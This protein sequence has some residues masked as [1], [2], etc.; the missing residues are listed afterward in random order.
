MS[1]KNKLEQQS[2]E[3]Q[4]LSQQRDILR[5]LGVKTKNPSC[6]PTCDLTYALCIC[7]KANQAGG[8]GGN[9]GGKTDDNS[10]T[11]KHSDN[12]K[13]S[14]VIKPHQDPFSISFTPGTKKTVEDE[15]N[16]DKQSTMYEAYEALVPLNQILGLFNTYLKQLADE[17]NIT[18]E[19][20]KKQGYSSEMRGNILVLKFPD[21]EKADTFTNMAFNAG[22]IRKPEHQENK[23]E[24]NSASASPFSKLGKIPELK[25]Y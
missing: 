9:S 19:E 18:V 21:K 8:S 25:P 7:P 13:K 3:S 10:N 22:F 15:K 20:L 6:C 17:Q 2:F 11:Q 12:D 23:S 5:R 14:P 16:P 24:E 1:N 4:S